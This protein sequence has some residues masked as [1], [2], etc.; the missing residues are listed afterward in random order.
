MNHLKWAPAAI[1]LASCATTTVASQTVFSKVREATIRGVDLTRTR[2]FVNLMQATPGS[3]RTVQKLPA[4]YASASVTLSNASLLTG[5]LVRTV[6]FATTSSPQII[7]S[8]STSFTRLRTGPGYGV[9]ISLFNAG[10]IVSTGRRSAL[11]LV[12]GTNVVNV[13]MSASG[14]IAITNSNQGNTV[15]TSGNWFITKG[16]TVTFD[17]GFASDE[18]TK[19]LVG[20]NASRSLSMRVYIGDGASDDLTNPAAAD[21]LVATTSAPF[22]SFTWDTSAVTNLGF[23]PM[24]S[25]TETGTQQS[26]IKFQ[27]VDDLG[28]VVGESIL[29]PV[30]VGGAAAIDLKLQ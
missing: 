15:G 24:T 10:S 6:N 7:A 2:L 4:N 28:A 16:D 13:I 9:D 17:T 30:S 22:D 8:G 3:Y 5:S 23:N 19:Y 12:A 11:T 18:H 1:L 20:D 26:R 25:L 21:T 29:T 14:D 27:I